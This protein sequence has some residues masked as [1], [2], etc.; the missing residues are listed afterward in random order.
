MAKKRKKKLP[1]PIQIATQ[2][3]YRLQ[4]T[5]TKKGKQKKLDRKQKQQ[6]WKD[7]L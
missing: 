5:P 4:M 6:G 3:T 1:N 2:L 7:H